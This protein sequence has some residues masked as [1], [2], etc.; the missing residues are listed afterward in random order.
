VGIGLGNG[1]SKRSAP[2][3]NSKKDANHAKKGNHFDRFFWIVNSSN[4][5]NTNVKLNNFLTNQLDRLHYDLSS[6]VA[7]FIILSF[8]SVSGKADD[9]SFPSRANYASFGNLR[10]GE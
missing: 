8:F 6:F 1:R 7:L 5:V 3:R 2:Q 9:I 4:D 10:Y